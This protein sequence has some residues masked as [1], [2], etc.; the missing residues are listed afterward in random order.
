MSRSWLLAV[1]GTMAIAVAAPASVRAGDEW[2]PVLDSDGVRVDS[3]D[4]AGSPVKEF[5]AYALFATSP[6]RLWAILADVESYPRNLPTTVSARRMGK[7]GEAALYYMVIDPPLIKRRD[8]CLRVKQSLF[9]D[10]KRK[11]EWK[12]TDTCPAPV[13]GLVR[14][15]ANSGAWL[16]IPVGKYTQVIYQ[17]HADPGGAVPAWMVNSASARTIRDLFSSLRRATE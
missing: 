8:Y 4:V 9:P 2:K 16:L 12:I 15:R 13:S 10:G 7:E 11:S 5:R 6:D 17:A 3:R 1:L 14:M